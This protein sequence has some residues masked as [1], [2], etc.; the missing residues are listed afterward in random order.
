[1]VYVDQIHEYPHS[2]I[3]G[4]KHKLWS[5]MWADSKEELLS[6][7]DKIGLQREWFQGDHFDVTPNKRKKAIENGAVEMSLKEYLKKLKGYLKKFD[8]VKLSV[9]WRDKC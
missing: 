5:H 9:F 1:M 3:R 4:C 7:G 2:R 8:N 6:F